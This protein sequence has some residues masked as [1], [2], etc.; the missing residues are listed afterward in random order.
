[1]EIGT[2]DATDPD[3]NP[4][5]PGTGNGDR[6]LNAPKRSA[7]DRPRHID[8]PGRHHF[9]HHIHLPTLLRTS[10][11]AGQWVEVKPPMRNRGS[12]GRTKGEYMANVSPVNGQP[13]CEVAKSTTEDV[14]LALDAAHAAKDAWGETSL[15]E[16]AA[17][18]NAIADVIEANLEMLAVAESWENGKPVRETLAADIPLA[19]DHFRYFAGATR[20]RRDGPPRSTRTPSPITSTSRSAWS[21]R[22]SRSTSRC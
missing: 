16:R 19:V 7:V 3:S 10:S 12:L 20:S 2:T 11:A 5:L 15:T 8:G 22:S 6:T 4:H 1:M 13:F 17:V 14:E 18:L 21:A 9:G